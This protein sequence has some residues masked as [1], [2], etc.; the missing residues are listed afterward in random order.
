MFNLTHQSTSRSSARN[1]TVVYYLPSF[2]DFKNLTCESYWN[3]LVNVN[4]TSTGAIY[5]KVIETK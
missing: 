5:I 2:V 1:L 4:A 3:D